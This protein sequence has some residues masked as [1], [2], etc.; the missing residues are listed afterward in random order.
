VKNLKIIKLRH[1][2]SEIENSFDMFS[3]RSEDVRFSPSGNRLIVATTENKLLLFQVDVA[4]VPINVKLLTALTSN[5][6]DSPHGVDWINEDTI[7]V[8]NRRAGLAL[9]QVPKCDTWVS[10]TSIQA[11]STHQSSWF[12]AA[13]E[14]REVNG[15]MV[16]T[17]PGSSRISQGYVY[18]G[19]N[20]KGTVTRHDF[21]NMAAFSQGELVAKEN[22]KIP[23]SSAVSPNGIFL[24]VSDHENGRLL[25][26]RLGDSFPCGEISD[27]CLIHPHGVVFDCSGSLLI[28]ADAG[29]RNLFLFHSP[30]GDWSSKISKA[31]TCVEALEIGIF[32][33]VRQETPKRFRNLEGGYKGVDIIYNGKVIVTTCRGQTVQFFAIDAS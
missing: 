22:I 18:V 20:Y 2:F 21:N 31:A 9:F 10:E 13:G 15:R 8:A 24:V 32:D 23:D 4:S 6:L 28:C 33:R 25:V 19:C 26:F 27:P 12:G 30:S 7:V 11:L 29:S 17:G 16:M 5:D 14:L 3:M 1:N